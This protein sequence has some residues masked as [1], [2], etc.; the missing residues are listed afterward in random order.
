MTWGLGY[1]LTVQITP[2]H[3]G[4]LE[5]A[6]LRTASC[7]P[8]GRPTDPHSA[9]PIASKLTLPS[10]V[11]KIQS[12]FTYLSASEFTTGKLGTIRDE[13]REPVTDVSDAE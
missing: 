3:E 6:L 1:I 8:I 7:L 9:T 12:R 2:F 13:K 10:T 4:L 11:S 5:I